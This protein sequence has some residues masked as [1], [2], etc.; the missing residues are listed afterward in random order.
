M[1][2]LVRLYG[3]PACIV[4]DNGTK[5]TNRAIPKWATEN[6][7]ECHHIDPGKPQQNDVIRS[8]NGSLRDDQLNEALFDSLSDVER[9]LAVWR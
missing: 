3:K 6:R 7:V 4:S 8:L 1:D 9:N 2:I 5:S